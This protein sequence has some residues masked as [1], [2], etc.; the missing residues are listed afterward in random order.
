MSGGSTKKLACDHKA[1]HLPD[2]F[3]CFGLPWETSTQTNLTPEASDRPQTRLELLKRISFTRCFFHFLI[4]SRIRS[5]AG[6][7]SKD[8]NNRTP[9]PNL[10][11]LPDPTPY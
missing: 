7:Y 2:L 5:V 3:D 8:H 4:S 9:P 6:I 1:Y 10:P 11:Y